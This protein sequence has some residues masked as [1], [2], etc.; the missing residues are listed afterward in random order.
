MVSELFPPNLPD[1][2]NLPEYPVLV[3]AASASHFTEV[4]DLVYNMS[5]V[6]QKYSDI[7]LVI[8]DLG[9]SKSQVEEVSVNIVCNA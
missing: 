5:A 3:T 2:H 9:F 8:Y 1:E 7:K 4:M 6:R